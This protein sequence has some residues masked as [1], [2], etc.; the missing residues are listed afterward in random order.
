M[1]HHFN[2]DMKEQIIDEEHF[3]SCFEKWI[4]E[5]KKGGVFIY[6]NIKLLVKEIVSIDRKFP[7]DRYSNKNHWAAN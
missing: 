3:Y 5:N 4:N 1:M 6:G 7:G 2:L